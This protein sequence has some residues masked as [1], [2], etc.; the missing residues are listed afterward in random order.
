LSANMIAG[1]L[2]LALL[3]GQGS[4]SLRG[5]TGLLAVFLVLLIILPKN[6]IIFL[7]NFFKSFLKLDISY[8]A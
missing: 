4:L 6:I 3:G 1:H 5:V 2:L 7:N 8:T